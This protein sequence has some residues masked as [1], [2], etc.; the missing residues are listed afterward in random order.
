MLDQPVATQ[1][2]QRVNGHVRLGVGLR[3][4]RTVLR[5]LFQS[6]AAKAML[7][8]VHGQ[9]PVAVLINTAGG[10][11]GG[12]RLKVEVRAGAGATL[13]LA[14]QTA[15][16]AYRAG[17]GRA[18]VEI[19]LS[20]GAGAHL[21]WLAQETILYEGAALSRRLAVD[22]APG[23]SALLV[24]PVVIGRAAMGEH[25]ENLVFQDRWR[26]TRAGRLIHAEAAGLHPPLGDLRTGA[27]L[28][29][30]RAFATMLYLGADADARAA[31]LAGLPA[32]DG[33]RMA[34]SCWDGRL[35]LR[36][37]ADD[38]QAMRA[39]LVAAMT[40]LHGHPPP[41]VWTM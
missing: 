14:T 19:R 37:L 30:A 20:A 32:R 33:V 18:E 29:A 16:R 25:P 11:T 3:N 28:G 12:D 22:L 39:G 10:L 26:I 27:G 23:A 2:H 6:G 40:R 4:G 1:R 13:T 36:F 38:P 41:R 24:E 8:K 9:H 34:Q 35:V 15:E 21:D 7:P 5:E 31:R 17:Q